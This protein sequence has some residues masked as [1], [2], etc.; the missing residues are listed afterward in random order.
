M[1]LAEKLLLVYLMG[2]IRLPIKILTLTLELSPKPAK[3]PPMDE[4]TLT[5]RIRLTHWTMLSDAFKRRHPSQVLLKQLMF[6]FQ[7]LN[8]KNKQRLKSF[9][10][11]WF[12]F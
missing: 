10:S 11:Q 12:D 4:H 3:R 6:D 8:E 7:K 9:Y 5:R 1:K 2:P